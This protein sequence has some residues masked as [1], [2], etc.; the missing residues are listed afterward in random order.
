MEEA[1][2]A[3]KKYCTK[4]FAAITMIKKKGELT[5]DRERSFT[6]AEIL[7]LCNWK[8]VQMKSNAKKREL[9]DA[10]V[11][12]P[13][14][15]IQTIWSRSE[16][17]ALQKLKDEVVELKATEIGVTT[18]QMARAVTNNLANLDSDSISALKAAID[19]IS[20]GD[21]NNVI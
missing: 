9:V 16:E 6:R 19:D 13:K 21:M 18:P 1:K 5:W 12:A 7:T 4:Q 2:T 8:K 17:A 3:R 15:K 20:N 11:D 10:Y 14:P